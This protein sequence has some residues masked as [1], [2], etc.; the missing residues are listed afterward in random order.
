MQ[1]L[2]I[3]RKL[4]HTKKK[5]KSTVPLNY[6][7]LEEITKQKYQKLNKNLNRCPKNPRLRNP[8][9]GGFE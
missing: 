1:G 8:K 4:E 9:K 6:I 7:Y 2:L 5:K 3:R